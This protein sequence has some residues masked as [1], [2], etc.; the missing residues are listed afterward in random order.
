MVDALRLA[1]LGSIKRFFFRLHMKCCAESLTEGP[2]GN[3]FASPRPRPR[4]VEMLLTEVLWSALAD[5]MGKGDGYNDQ[6]IQSRT[7]GE[8][9]NTAG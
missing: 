8:G 1:H 9:V 2:S 3:C 5:H 6:E 4:S 7:G